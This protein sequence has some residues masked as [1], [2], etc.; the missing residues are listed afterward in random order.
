MKNIQI[1]IDGP[2]G[3][4]KSTMAKMIARELDILYLDTG[5]MYRAVALKAI[6]SGIDTK[7]SQALSEMVKNINL[8]IVYQDGTQKVILDGKNVT[9]DI[10]TPKVT[11]GSS[12][13]AV[14]PA[15]REKMV[16]LQREIGQEKS[17]IMDGRDIGT[18]VLPEAD[19]KIFLTASVEDRTRRRYE[20]LEEK[21]TL[22]QT[23]EELMEEMAYRDK[24]DSSRAHSPLKKAEG[25]ILLDTTGFSIED[26]ARTILEIIKSRI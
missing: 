13:V 15:V 21:G 16:E 18:K 24:N 14:I 7:D 26:S 4:G 10:R 2:S 3:A 23:F 5:A 25:A 17:V 6:L 9:E 22:K 20:E 1:A 19:I 11:V 8:N 12:D